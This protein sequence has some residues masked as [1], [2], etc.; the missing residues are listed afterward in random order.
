MGNH[1]LAVTPLLFCGQDGLFFF[2]VYV[3][4]PTPAENNSSINFILMRL[5]YFNNVIYYKI[6]D[7]NDSSSYS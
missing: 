5:K 2:Y 4:R 7:A 3:T 1:N 6:K